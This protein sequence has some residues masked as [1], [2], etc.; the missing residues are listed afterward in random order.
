MGVTT[1]GAKRSRENEP[2]LNLPGL[3][4]SIS[5]NPLKHPCP[6][7]IAAPTEEA[8]WV[9]VNQEGS[10]KTGHLVEFGG[11]GIVRNYVI[12]LL[13]LPPDGEGEEF[14]KCTPIWPLKKGKRKSERHLSNQTHTWKRLALK[15]PYLS[16]KKPIQS[17]WYFHSA[18]HWGRTLEKCL[19]AL[20][21]FTLQM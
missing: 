4:M 6:Y 14:G 1:Q 21:T 9:D 19:W 16:G 17:Q 13:L 20:P 5:G 12:C 8:F 2:I 11:R 10:L 15:K 18:G 3:I 7:M